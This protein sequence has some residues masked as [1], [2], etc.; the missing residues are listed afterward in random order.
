MQHAVRIL[1]V[2]ACAVT[3]TACEVE[4]V[5]FGQTGAALARDRW[6]P[7]LDTDRSVYRAWYTQDRI[8]LDIGFRFVN[9][10]RQPVAI[11]GCGHAYRPSLD[12]L[13]GGEWVEVLSYREPCWDEP[14]VIGVGRERTFLYRIRAG[15]PHTL[16][17]PQFQTTHLPGTYRLRW[18]IYE[19]DAFSQFRIGNLLPTEYRV[20]NTFRITD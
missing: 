1:G 15:R 17:E 14:L 6:D 7:W 8:E 16:I 20:S 11:P 9:R 2:L 12:K 19:Y 4:R 3:L 5:T 18:E 10:L 13:V